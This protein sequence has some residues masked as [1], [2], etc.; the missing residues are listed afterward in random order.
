MTHLLLSQPSLLLSERH[1][2]DCPSFN[3][4][5]FRQRLPKV[6]LSLGDVVGPL[7]DTADDGWVVPADMGDGGFAP[8]ETGVGIGADE[9]DVFRNFNASGGEEENGR[10]E[11]E[12]FVDDQRS[13]RSVFKEGAEKIGEACLVLFPVRQVEGAT[14]DV[15]GLELVD[16]GEGG[17]GRFG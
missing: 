5:C 1:R 12:G 15:G 11:E 13:G 14:R 9:R 7:D 4:L 17:A 3:Q 6:F 16:K 2:A 10:V 8:G